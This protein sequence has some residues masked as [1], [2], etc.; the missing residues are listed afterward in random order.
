MAL[1]LFPASGQV[2]GWGCTICSGSPTYES[3]AGLKDADDLTASR[4]LWAGDGFSSDTGFISEDWTV[5][6]CPPDIQIDLLKV[7]VRTA[8]INAFGTFDGAIQARLNSI[9]YGPQPPLPPIGFADFTFDFT[10]DP[11][12]GQPWTPAKVNA[13]KFGYKATVTSSDPL[14]GGDIWISALR[15]ELYPGTPSTPTIATPLSVSNAVESGQAGMIGLEGSVGAIAHEATVGAQVETGEAGA[16]VRAGSVDGINLEAVVVGA[17]VI[18]ADAGA[19]II[20]GRVVQMA[21]EATVGHHVITGD[22]GTINLGG[23]P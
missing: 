4:G 3:A 23:T 17:Q 16:I 10:T 9:D 18:D 11:A 8:R 2:P 12:D 13:Q 1:S 20:S 15:I 6:A 14:S 19:I 7:V 5:D 22:A 21:H